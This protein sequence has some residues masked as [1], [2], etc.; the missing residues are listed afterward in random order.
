MSLFKSFII[1]FCNSLN[2][3]L[4]KKNIIDSFISS[5]FGSTVAGKLFPEEYAHKFQEPKC[6]ILKQVE[7]LP[8]HFIDSFISILSD[9]DWYV[10]LLIEGSE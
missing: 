6:F 7:C 1:I 2:L 3:I 5:S 8:A 10:L 4:S 9:P